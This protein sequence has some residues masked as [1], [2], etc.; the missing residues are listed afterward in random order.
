M[1]FN[2]TNEEFLVNGTIT[3]YDDILLRL[4][5]SI[6]ITNGTD[7]REDYYSILQA[8]EDKWY[9]DFGGINSTSESWFNKVL[10]SQAVHGF[11]LSDG[12]LP[13]ELTLVIPILAQR[14]W[15]FDNLH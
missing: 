7:L 3:K 13:G 4:D 2:I 15:P 12:Y 9:L 11:F 1:D 14:I 6:D 5:A 8:E 10:A